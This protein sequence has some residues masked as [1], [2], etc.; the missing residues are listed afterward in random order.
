MTA[1]AT[2]PQTRL[3]HRQVLIVFSGLMLG[4]LLASLD[5]TI[6]STA[7]PTIVGDLGGLNHLSWVV[8]AYL[9]TSTASVPLFGKISD[10][11]GR[12]ILFQVAIVIFLGGSMV[13]GAAPN[14]LTLVLARGLQGIG[15]G[16]LM[17]MSMIIIGDIVSPRERGRYQGYTGAVFA[18]SSV[19]G[20][21]LG[22]FFTD[23]LSWRWIFY[24][25]L[26]LGLLALVVTSAVLNLPFVRRDHSVDY[27]G[28]GLLVAGV[29]SLLLVTVWGGNEYAWTSATVIGL[30]VV[31][32]LLLVAFVFQEGRASEPILPLDLFRNPVFRVASGVSFLVGLSMFGSTI[33]LPI[34]FQIVTGASATKSGL[35]VVP[36]VAGLMLTSISSGGIISRR[37]KYRIFPIA[38]SLITTVGL[39]LLSRLDVDT[40]RVE[41]SLYM[42]V[43]GAGLGLLMQTLVLAV[44]N[45]ASHEHLGA[46]TAGVT[47][48]RS[49][50]GA[51]G[52][53][54]LGT[55]LNNRLDYYVPRN[56]P[57]NLLQ[58]LGSPS[59]SVLGRSRQVIDHLPDLARIG[60]IQ[61]FADS[62][63]VVFLVTV[64]LGLLAFGL[65]WFLQE[66]PLRDDV[67]VGHLSEVDP[68][69][70]AS[71]DRPQRD[72][73]AV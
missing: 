32:V 33:F 12:K 9:L 71:P 28:A 41:S 22:G 21:L 16:G 55:I 6:V 49:M 1:L 37:G 15:G 10:L 73:E 39:L 67:G 65:T 17:S 50:G 43:L 4:M 8:T 72:A 23:S 24:I 63:Q 36:M 52:V 14:M 25:N 26:P 64:P 19:V 11:Y 20:P 53:A 69:Q 62:L 40:S 54:I 45:A 7:L 27:L 60:V 35:L 30:A 31:G 58:Q 44:Q 34:Y 68:E 13:S 18:T 57:A 66:V 70:F 51:F 29:S 42:F 56:V 3:T 5:Q 2:A 47:F 61:S 59:G 48:F 46:A 38:G